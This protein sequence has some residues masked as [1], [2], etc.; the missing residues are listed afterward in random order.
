MSQRKVY[1]PKKENAG[2]KRMNT[3]EINTTKI[4]TKNT[5]YLVIVESP[6]KCKKIE[7]YLG[8]QYKCIASKG[9]ICGIEKIKKTYEPVFEILEEKKKHVENMREI[10]SH[11]LPENI[12]LGTDDDREGEAIAWHI[13]LVFGLPVETVHRIVFHEITESA[14]RAAVAFPMKIRMNIVNAQKARQ[15]LDRLVGFQISPLLSKRIAHSDTS[16]LSAGRCQTPALRLIYDLEQSSSKGEIQYH[17]TGYFFQQNLAC[18]LSHTFS[19]EQ[20][21]ITFLEESRQFKHTYSLDQAVSKTTNPPLPFCTSSLLQYASSHL[22]FSPKQTMNYCQILYQNGWITYMRTESI[23]YSQDFVKKVKEYVTDPKWLGDLSKVQNYNENNPHEA[24]RVTH[25]EKRVL[26]KTD[27]ECEIDNYEL[28]RILALYDKIRLRTL[29]SC[30]SNYQYKQISLKITAPLEYHYLYTIEIP[31]FLGWKI[32]NI[33]EKEFVETQDKQNAIYFFLQNLANKIVKPNKIDCKVG[34]GN[35]TRHYCEASLI[36]KLEDLGIGRPSTF[37]TIVETIQ[38]RKY[39]LKQD[40]EGIKMDCTEFSME[41]PIGECTRYKTE[42]IVGQEKN[43]LVLQPLGKEVIENLIPTFETLFSYDYTKKMETELDIVSNGELVWTAICGECDQEI[44]KCSTEW[45]TEMKETYW[46][47]DEH[48]LI[49]SKHGVIIRKKINIEKDKAKYEYR[50]VR[51]MKIDITKLKNREYTLAELLEI[52][53]E[54]L[55]KYQGEDLILKKGPYGAYV[56]WGSNKESINNIK[57]NIWDITMDDILEYF[58]QQPE[59]KISQNT[60]RVLTDKISIR[61]G[62]FGPYIHYKS[63][64]KPEFYNLKPF[65]QSSTTSYMKCDKEILLKWIA[66]SYGICG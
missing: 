59:N 28:H 51:N 47:D 9:H 1:K 18:T 38:E 24:I 66:E 25:L 10:I 32:W 61:K 8:F 17:T 15:V 55:G 60:L 23:K 21:C 54:Y 41:F 22:H 4:N 53:N 7:K 13:C 2:E 19:A 57:K 62:K 50:Q 3:K 26:Q 56:T 52:P 40:I 31:A 39:V 48:E 64:L 37:A 43:K 6:S 65:I 16:F 11:F 14:I 35:K 49:F 44:K 33:T 36:G 29:E 27:F 45:K 12:Y 58:L 34:F 63:A 30:G 20:E 46:I 5:P 42:K